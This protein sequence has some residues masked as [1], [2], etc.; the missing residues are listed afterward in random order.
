MHYLHSRGLLHEVAVVP[1]FNLVNATGIRSK[2]IEII[3]NWRP[4]CHRPWLTSY[5]LLQPFEPPSLPLQD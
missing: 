1:L 2:E 4:M 5:T 3:Q